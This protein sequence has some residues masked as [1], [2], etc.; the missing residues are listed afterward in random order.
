MG[1]AR[2]LVVEDVRH[3]AHFVQHNLKK[4]GYE[5]R[6]VH[7]GDEVLDAVRDFS[8]DAVLLDMVLPGMSGLEICLALRGD[9]AHKDLRIVIVT[10]HS[11]DDASADEVDAAGADWSFTKPISPVNMLAKLRELGVPPQPAEATR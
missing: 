3:I 5:T 6:V 7:H 4:A 2:V 11:F 8:P 10:G 9:P 1:R